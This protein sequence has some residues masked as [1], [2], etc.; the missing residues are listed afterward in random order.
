[1][2]DTKTYW[3]TDRRSLHKFENIRSPSE[4]EEEEGSRPIPP[5]VEEETPL[6]SSDGGGGETNRHTDRKEIV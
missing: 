1:V 6:P 4:R 5:L 2:L 3:P